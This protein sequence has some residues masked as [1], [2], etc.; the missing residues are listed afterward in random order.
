MVEQWDKNYTGDTSLAPSVGPM[1]YYPKPKTIIIG[2]KRIVTDKV[3]GYFKLSHDTGKHGVQI[4]FID[5][6]QYL[7]TLS[8]DEA[9]IDELINKLD[10]LFEAKEL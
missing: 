6:E 2:N 8:D 9:E 4:D 5:S 10:F 7:I 3:S 1:V